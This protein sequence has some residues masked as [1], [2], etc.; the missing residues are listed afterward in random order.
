[1][2]VRKS[3]ATWNVT[4]VLLRM[5]PDVTSV[6]VQYPRIHVPTFSVGTDSSATMVTASSTRPTDAIRRVMT[7]KSVSKVNVSL[8]PDYARS[9]CAAM[10]LIVE[11]AIVRR[12]HVRRWHVILPVIMASPET[13][14][15]VRSANVSRAMTCVPTLIAHKV[16]SVE[17]AI[18]KQILNVKCQTCSASEIATVK[19]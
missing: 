5:T 7:E 18:V 4:L 15:A 16:K 10:V 13:M 1:M 6:S 14:P 3:C 12:L 11:L 2:A 8:L 17:R 19:I 9:W